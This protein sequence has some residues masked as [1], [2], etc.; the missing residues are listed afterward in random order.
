MD[1]AKVSMVL[2]VDEFVEATIN[3]YCF[4]KPFSSQ[5]LVV[6]LLLKEV[7][8]PNV[9]LPFKEVDNAKSIVHLSLGEAFKKLG[10]FKWLAHSM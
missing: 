6:R 3:M 1:N 2:I 8:H 4:Q 7:M 10:A 9:L 5:T